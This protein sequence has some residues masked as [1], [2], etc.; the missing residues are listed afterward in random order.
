MQCDSCF[1]LMHCLQITYNACFDLLTILCIF[2][3]SSY[4][5]TMYSL[6]KMCI[7]HMNICVA[8]KDTS[9]TSSQSIFALLYTSV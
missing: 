2:N 4:L 9:N 8:Y 3:H 7:D 6:Y 1:M 5:T